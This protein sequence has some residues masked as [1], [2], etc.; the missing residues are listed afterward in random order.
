MEEI[1]LVKGI[2]AY[3][4]GRP[5]IDEKTNYEKIV[6]ELIA[7]PDHHYDAKIPTKREYIRQCAKRLGKTF[8][9]RGTKI[10]YDPKAQKG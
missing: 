8:R 9:S 3:R 2:P 5:L 4:R 10:W 7:H 1:K 6:E